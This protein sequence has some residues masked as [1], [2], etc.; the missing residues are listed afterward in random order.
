MTDVYCR[1]VNQQKD[2]IQSARDPAC[3][4]EDDLSITRALTGLVRQAQYMCAAKQ[5][6]IQRGGQRE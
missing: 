5:G 1:L 4:I 3:S 6:S 2:C